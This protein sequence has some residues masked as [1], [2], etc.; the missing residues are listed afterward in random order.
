MTNI[1]DILFFIDTVP[2]TRGINITPGK[3]FCKKQQVI[4]YFNFFQ[5]FES[6]FSK[7]LG[8]VLH[9]FKMPFSEQYARTI[10]RCGLPL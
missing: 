7:A 10:Y 5:L 9:F 6:F 1:M 4:L 8:T 3:D 2:L